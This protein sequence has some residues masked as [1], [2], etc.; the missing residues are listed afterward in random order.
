[1]IEEERY[2]SDL[3]KLKIENQKTMNK[4]IS[5]MESSIKQSVEP[6]QVVS[7]VK[8]LQK[9]FK[10]KQEKA[11]KAAKKNLLEDEDAF[12]HVNFT[13]TQ[14]PV[15]PTP[16]PQQV[17]IAKPFT[18]K[19]HN[20]RVC[21]FVKDPESDFRKQIA[22]LKIPCIAEVIGFDRLKRDFH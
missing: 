2:T 20:S 22:N 7:A 6:K 3:V 18:T 21:I 12:V 9:Y 16:R 15:K 5:K 8:A 13:L 11:G 4:S 10:A 1:M 19:E 14:A 17:K